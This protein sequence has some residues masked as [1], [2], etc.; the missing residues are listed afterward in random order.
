MAAGL[1]IEFVREIYARMD[2]KEL[3]RVLTQDVSGLTPEAVDVVKEEVKKRNL[4][5]NISRGIDAQQ[6]S[7]TVQEIDVY[8]ELIRNLPC[9]YTNSTDN[10]LNGTMT[11]EVMSF[12][13]FSEYKEDIIIGSPQALDKANNNALVKSIL[14]GWWGI[15]WGIIRTIQAINTNLNNKKTNHLGVPNDFLRSYVISRIG[16]IET[17]K[18]NREKLIQIISKK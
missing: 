1:D 8:C 7:F 5:P 11:A 15:P 10:K 17:Y 14:L 3:I 16:E 18:N 4:D 6:K 2:D 9:P 13:L 12:I